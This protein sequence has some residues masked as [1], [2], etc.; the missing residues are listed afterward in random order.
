VYVICVAAM[1]QEKEA[2]LS[3]ENNNKLNEEEGDWLKKLTD[4]AG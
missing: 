2:S 1:H 3:Q 4:F